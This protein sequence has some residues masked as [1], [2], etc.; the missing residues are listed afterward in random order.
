MNKLIA[1]VFAL[2]LA[3]TGA[4]IAGMWTDAGNAA[5]MLFGLAM[6]LLLLRLINDSDRPQ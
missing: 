2:A 6:I 4:R 5:A 3:A 1:L